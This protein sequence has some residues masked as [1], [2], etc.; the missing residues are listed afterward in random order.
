[1]CQKWS[2]LFSS[3]GYKDHG[4]LYDSAVGQSTP[5]RHLGDLLVSRHTEQCLL[6]TWMI[7]D[8]WIMLRKTMKRTQSRPRWKRFKVQTLKL[9]RGAGKRGEIK[10]GP[11]N[12]KGSWNATEKRYE[13]GFMGPEAL[14]LGSWMFVTEAVLRWL[15][16]AK[17]P[18]SAEASLTHIC[19]GT[20]KINLSQSQVLL[21]NCSSFPLRGCKVQPMFFCDLF[22]CCTA[23][24]GIVPFLYV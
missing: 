16:T 8:K 14:S 20:W 23:G 19:H 11:E 6:E 5:P 4:P 17:R 1:M 12:R 24:K 21:G 7:Q 13:L 22:Q 9:K 2:W 10:G 15:Q 3:S 18:H